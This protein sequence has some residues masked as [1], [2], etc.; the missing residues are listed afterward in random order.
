MDLGDSA[1]AKRDSDAC[2]ALAQRIAA[3]PLL[4]APRAPKRAAGR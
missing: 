2:R 3:K 4:P 1:D